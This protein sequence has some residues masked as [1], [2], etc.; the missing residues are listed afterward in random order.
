MMARNCG[1]PYGEPMSSEISV[2]PI[3]VLGTR[4]C[5]DCRMARRL[6]DRAG[7]DYDWV[8]IDE[9]PAAREEVM[10]LNRGMR[11]VPTIL[12]SDGSVLVEPSR[13]ALTAGLAATGAVAPAA[14]ACATDDGIPNCETG[15]AGRFGFVFRE[16]KAIVTRRAAKP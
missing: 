9:D 10:R 2:A 8:D 16:L 13:R 14:A 1:M 5:G 6:L 4:W 7:V 11:S 12:F 15:P 3:R